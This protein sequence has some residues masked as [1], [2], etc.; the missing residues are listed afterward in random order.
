M[1]DPAIVRLSFFI[2]GLILFACWEYYAPRK[3]LTQSKLTRWGNN[4]GLV[5]LNSICLAVIMPI[6]A[7]DSALQA[8]QFGFGLFHFFEVPALVNILLSVL[9]LDFAI[10]VQHVMFHR[11]PFLWRL[12][13]MHHA[14]QDIDVT[15][16]SRFHPIEI[17][18]SMWIKIA[19]VLALGVSPIAIVVFEIVLN[20][21]AMFNHSNGKLPLKLDFWL[22]KILVTPDMHRVHHSVEV[23]ETHSNFGFFLSVWDQWFG[24][25]RDQP[26][27]GHDEV[28]I[29]LPLFRKPKEQQLWKML[30][31]PFRHD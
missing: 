28:E 15:T 2:G 21:S 23:K 1:E 3:S 17:I 18:L 26:K 29:G 31:Q 6:V 20:V 8:Q 30:T 19:L 25:Y 22:R 10:Y 11:L 5:G 7:F 14:D 12:H 16:G 27:K 4:L 24:T 9:I 13:R